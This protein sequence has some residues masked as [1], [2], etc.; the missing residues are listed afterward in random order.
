[1]YLLERSKDLEMII[2]ATENAVNEQRERADVSILVLSKFEHGK[3][4]V[5]IRKNKGKSYSVMFSG[6]PV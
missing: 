2:T 4:K 6:K 1:M 5:A 3:V